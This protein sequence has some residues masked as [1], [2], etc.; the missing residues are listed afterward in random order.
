M[1]YGSGSGESYL[2]ELT[3][4]FL[5]DT[6]QYRV[7]N[8]VGG[9]LIDDITVTGRCNTTTSTSSI[10]LLFGNVQST[11]VGLFFLLSPTHTLSD[12]YACVFVRL[13]I[14]S[15]LHPPAT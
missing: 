2:S 13:F 8:D 5:E 9:R 4:A 12:A 14:V 11:N 15:Q 10:D 7:A 6:G 1:S 3:L